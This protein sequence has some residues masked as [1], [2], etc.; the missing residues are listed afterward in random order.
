MNTSHI[1][2]LQLLHPYTALKK[3]SNTEG[4]EYHGPCPLC[5]G[6]DRFCVWPE[7]GRFWCRRCDA[8][9]DAIEFVQVHGNVSFEQ[10]VEILR[11]G[12][13]T[14]PQTTQRQPIQFPDEKAALG[15]AMWQLRAGEFELM[16]N[17][18]LMQ[19]AGEK[20]LKY[21][22]DRGID[23]DTLNVAGIGYNQCARYTEWGD[24]EVYLPRSITIPWVFDGKLW[25]INM[26]QP[27]G[28]PKYIC[29]KGSAN[30]LYG[31]NFVRP[32]CTVVMF[33]GEL[34]ALLFRSQLKHYFKQ[35]IIPVATGSN[36]GARRLRWLSLLSTARRV[37]LAFDADAAGD[38]AA[39]V[40]QGKLQGKAMRLRPTAHDLGDMYAQGQNLDEWLEAGISEHIERVG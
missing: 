17:E 20:A 3:V 9:G 4:G 6:V 2:L 8:K 16:C 28:D 14:T 19:P 13:Y 11:L 27:K 10:A 23:R 5:G 36:T 35:G 25:K 7:K 12:D 39:E 33:E 22:L 18:L 37:L 21:L 31:A 32:D 40:W 34:D 26:R 38:S 30:G 15:D 24:I 29:A 1:D